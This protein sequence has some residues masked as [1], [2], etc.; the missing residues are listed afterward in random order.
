MGGLMK[1]FRS[2][3]ESSGCLLFSFCGNKLSKLF[4]K[5]FNS[6]ENPLLIYL[7]SSLPCSFCLCRHCPLEMDRKA[8]ILHLHSF[9]L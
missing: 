3:F 8:D 9:N 7:S 5:L 4:E 6:D 2:L 1:N